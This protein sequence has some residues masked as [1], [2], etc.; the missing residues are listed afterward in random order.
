MSKQTLC[1]LEAIID[2]C[3]KVKTTNFDKLREQILTNFTYCDLSKCSITPLQLS[4]LK[5]SNGRK[6]I[7]TRPKFRE[8]F[9]RQLYIALHKN[10]LVKEKGND[11]ED[12]IFNLGV[13]VLS[14]FF[15][16]FI[17]LLK[18]SDS[19]IVAANPRVDL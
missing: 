14:T 10:N 5:E 13:E 9:R 19:R 12:V 18:K 3:C 17:F 15:P 1:G 6:L 16:K 7:M 11:I 4:R 2:N 8:Y